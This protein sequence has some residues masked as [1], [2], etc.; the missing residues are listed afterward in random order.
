MTLH[1]QLNTIMHREWHQFVLGLLNLGKFDAVFD[2]YDVG[3]S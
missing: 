1:D 2:F 3:K